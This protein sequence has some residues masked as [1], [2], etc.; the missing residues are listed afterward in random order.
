MPFTPLMSQLV[1]QKSCSGLFFTVVGA[2]WSLV[3]SRCSS[4]FA[5]HDH[6]PAF[7]KSSLWFLNVSFFDMS[8][9]LCDPGLCR[10]NAFRDFVDIDVHFFIKSCQPDWCSG[11]FLQW[12]VQIFTVFFHDVPLPFRVALW[13]RLVCVVLL[14]LAVQPFRWTRHI[15]FWRSR[16]ESGSLF[17]VVDPLQLP[18]GVD[19]H[20]M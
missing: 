19:L 1:F 9:L 2:F 18:V 6:G 16:L 20:F 13:C 14:Q 8:R 4:R 7:F 11:W 12:F 15:D 10:G 5:T 17:C 3:F